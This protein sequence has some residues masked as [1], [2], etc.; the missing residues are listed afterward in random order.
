M[1]GGYAIYKFGITIAIIIQDEIY[2]KVNDINIDDYTKI[3]SRPFTYEK[4]GKI[5]ALSNWYL[6][7]EILEDQEKLMEFVDKSYLVALMTKK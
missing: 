5:I 3:N 2:F 4:K 6:P 7:I 1:F